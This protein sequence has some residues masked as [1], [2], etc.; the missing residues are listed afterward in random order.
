MLLHSGHI[1]V[2]LISAK[3]LAGTPGS[4]PVSISAAVRAISQQGLGE[5]EFK[6]LDSFTASVSAIMA[7]A[8]GE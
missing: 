5:G 2:K 6:L 4:S 3:R 8:S 7:H 1:P